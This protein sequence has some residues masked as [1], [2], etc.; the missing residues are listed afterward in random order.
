[1]T[2]ATAMMRRGAGVVIILVG[3]FFAYEAIVG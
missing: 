2:R 3:V 1:M